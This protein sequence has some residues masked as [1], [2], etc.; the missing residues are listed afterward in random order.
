MSRFADADGMVD[1]TAQLSSPDYGQRSLAEAAVRET[2]AIKECMSPPGALKLPPKLEER[3]LKLGITDGA[4]KFQ[5]IYDR[6]FVHQVSEYGIH[7]AGHGGLIT[8][9]DQG[10]QREEQSCPQGILVSAGPEALDALR[11]NGV[12][13]GD[14][15]AFIRQ[16][17]YR[18]E[19]DRKDGYSWWV[20]V[21]H[22]GDLIASRDLRERMMGGEIVFGYDEAQS[23]H[24]LTDGTGQRWA[25]KSPYQ[26][27]EY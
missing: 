3:R 2:K 20:L 15:C 22:A 26:P 21:F 23:Q 10:K 9:S 1:M 25:P 12:E 14:L 13:L 5:P 8:L 17:P 11:S 27:S 7:A 24:Y 19:V 16:A 18:F 4:F 6:I